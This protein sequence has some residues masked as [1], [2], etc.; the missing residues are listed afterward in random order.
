MAGSRRISTI[1]IVGAGI[2]GL[3]LALYLK[4]NGMHPIVFE[5]AERL[6]P[7]GAGIMLAN[8][9][10]QI[11][12]D[13]GLA[14]KIEAAGNRIEGVEI[15]DKNEK[16]IMSTQVDQSESGIYNIAIH[17]ADLQHIL[18]QA[19][20]IEN[21]HLNKRL[22]RLR[23]DQND[24]TLFFED[25]TQTQCQMLFGADGLH[26]K[27][28][29]FVDP[30]T[31][32]RN[33]H[34]VCWRGICDN[35]FPEIDNKVGIEFWGYGE[36]FG[37]TVIN[38]SQVYWYAVC[39]AHLSTQG[40]M[41]DRVLY[42]N[43]IANKIIA[44]TDKKYIHFSS[45]SDLKPL[46]KWYKD[47]VCLIGDAAHATTPNLGQGGCQAIEDAFAIGKLLE[48]GLDF[49][50]IFDSFQSLRFQKV[51]VIVKQSH[52]LGRVSHIENKLLAKCRNI[53][54]RMTP[55]SM[56][57]KQLKFISNIDYIK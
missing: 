9:A 23:P 3:T 54:M 43:D 31:E 25:G 49:P 55:A 27:V 21:I 13:L 36:R 44:Q 2:G 16:T 50:Q 18:A 45:I 53:A 4:K 29:E 19:L 8:N 6:E 42:F 35:H 48:K 14:A 51:N 15:A 47:N 32:I 40:L 5:S 33:A 30:D 46:N 38:K 10:M 24:I 26:S 39:N 37:Y 56:G 28:R 52:L 41:P 20:G 12:Q 57:K 17:R 7:I 11:F 22:E 34:Q 1:A